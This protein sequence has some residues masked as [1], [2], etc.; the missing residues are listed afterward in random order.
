M[1]PLGVGVLVAVLGEIVRAKGLLLLTIKA[2]QLAGMHVT[3][4]SPGGAAGAE[5]DATYSP[6]EHTRVALVTNVDVGNTQVESVQ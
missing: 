6:L 1:L 3:A 5:F 2:G 4:T